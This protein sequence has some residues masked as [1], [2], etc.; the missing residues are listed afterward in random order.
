MVINEITFW[1]RFENKKLESRFLHSV[2]QEIVTQNKIGIVSAGIAYLFVAIADYFKLGFCS[3]FELSLLCRFIFFIYCLYCY[4]IFKPTIS[5]RKFINHSFIFAITNT[6]LLFS[7]IYWLNPDKKIDTIDSITVPFITL[8]LFVFLQLKLSYVIVNSIIATV[9]YIFML[10][11]VFITS[12]D[13]IINMSAIMIVLNIA[14]LF[15]ARFIRISQRRQFVQS[16]EI[17]QLNSNLTNEIHER[18]AMQDE[19]EYTFKELS[20]SIKYAK[21][22]QM[23]FMPAETVIENISKD[24]FILFKP[25]DE[26]SGDFYW[27]NHMEDETIIAI[28]DCTGH[29]IPGAF[30]SILG[31]TLLNKIVKELRQRLN[32]FTAAE[33]LDNLRIDLISSVKSTQSGFNIKDGMNL[34]LCIINE[35]KKQIQFSGAYHNLWFFR[36]V[37][38]KPI[39]TIFKGDSMPIGIHTNIFDAFTNHIIDIKDKDSIILSTDGFQDQ[40]GGLQTKRFQSKQLRE[41]LLSMYYKPMKDQKRILKKVFKDWKGK[42]DQI[43]D[44]LILGLR[45]EFAEKESGTLLL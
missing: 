42:E 10:T 28:A 17:K 31:I 15:L 14:G 30:M 45:F 29:G 35:T 13:F 33:I 41:L 3:S 18:I 1:G 16:L 43:D 20:S 8:L 22:L 25:R 38:S 5:Y 9:G 36:E 12:L 39:M 19:L 40:F 27:I 44:V 37:D 2:N 26:V 23:T 4:V 11:F 24:Y 34:S 32:P 21:N 7:L 6:I